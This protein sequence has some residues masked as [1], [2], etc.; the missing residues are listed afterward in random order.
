MFNILPEVYT[1]LSCIRGVDAL[2]LRPHCMKLVT[3][4]NALCIDPLTSLPSNTPAQTIPV[5]NPPTNAPNTQPGT[6]LY[7]H[8]WCPCCRGCSQH[9]GAKHISNHGCRRH[10]EHPKPRTVIVCNSLATTPVL[11]PCGPVLPFDNG[12]RGVHGMHAY[13]GNTGRLL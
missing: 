10:V 8:G 6:L 1:L 5:I 11:T 4:A 12:G 3:V 2:W 13:S 9:Q 7:V